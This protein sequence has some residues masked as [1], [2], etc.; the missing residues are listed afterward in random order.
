MGFTSLLVYP[1]VW[2]KA[3][4]D[5]DSNQY[6]TYILAYVDE[7]IIVEEDPHKLMSMLMDNHTE[8]TPSK[9]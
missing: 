8:N 1:D 3:S 7:I 2:F 9:G 6:N 4:T 5:K